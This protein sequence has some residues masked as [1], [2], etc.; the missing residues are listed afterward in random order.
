MVFVVVVVFRKCTTSKLRLSSE[1]CGETVI[2]FHT[3]DQNCGKDLKSN[4]LKAIKLKNTTLLAHCTFKY[5][6]RR[7][8]H[9]K[10]SFL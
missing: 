10:N 1:M 2:C 8:G 4:E 3:A 9:L 7:P 5:I 6:L